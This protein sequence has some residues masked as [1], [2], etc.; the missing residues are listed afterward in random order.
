MFQ[1]A[2][3][4]RPTVG[5]ITRR[6]VIGASAA[7]GLVLATSGATGQREQLSD[8]RVATNLFT[9]GPP[10]GMGATI[11]SFD[12]TGSNAADLHEDL[13][14]ISELGGTWARMNLSA[15]HLVSDWDAPDGPVTLRPA[16]VEQNHALLDD[17]AQ[18]GLAI[19][20]MYINH[21]PRTEASHATWVERTTA[22]WRVASAEFAPKIAM[23]QIF[24]EAAGHHYR[25]YRDVPAVR[26]EAY[27]R[28]MA[29]LILLA[30][31]VIHEFNPQVQVTTN[32]YG[33]P[34]GPD[35]EEQWNRELQAL[36]PVQ[37]LL[38]V[39]AY[40]D[41]DD[42]GAE[43]LNGLIPRIA[44]LEETFGKKIAIGEIGVPGLGLAPSVH[45]DRLERIVTIVKDALPTAYATFLYQ[46]RDST[47]GPPFEQT[48]G[49]LE[50]D[51][52]PKE[53]FLRLERIGL[54]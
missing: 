34:V 26:E 16:A 36:A 49:L 39:D 8:R 15:G 44:R 21:Y 17:A 13:R 7:T 46:L 1:R 9:S 14:R 38:T 41:W 5:Q 23:A 25:F 2:R 29:D 53:A 12:D 31:S 28:E 30:R 27:R 50:A 18:R 6:R 33:W 3:P 22:W 35:I 47:T 42:E 11:G 45:A 43:T 32:L 20:M 51:G 10:P 37:D 40:V 19:C 48:F 24:N 52:T 54:A 4:E